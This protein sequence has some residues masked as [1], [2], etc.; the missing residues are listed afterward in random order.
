MPVKAADRPLE[1]LRQETIDQLI[2]NYSQG[3][4]SMEAFERRLDIASAATE[5]QALVELTDDLDLEADPNYSE[6]KEQLLNCNYQPGHARELEHMVNVFS[7]S[8]STYS[9]DLPK[10]IKLVEVF[11]GST[12][13]LTE[14]CFRQ[15]SLTI[16]TIS[17]FSGPT[18]YV[19]ENVRVVSKVFCIFGSV[20]NKVSATTIEE[21]PVIYVEGFALFS[22]IDI[23]LKKTIKE[24]LVAFA[25]SLKRNLLDS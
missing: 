14:A 21:G 5:H 25:Q 18:I 8:D 4:L 12:I 9:G 10:Q 7:G 13:D 23:K 2:V 16:N 6:S 1:K 20:S 22:G 11:S 15:P 24:R 17:V 19:P 3:E